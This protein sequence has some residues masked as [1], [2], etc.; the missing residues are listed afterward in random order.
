MEGDIGI[1]RTWKLVKQVWMTIKMKH[2]DG[3][4]RS[5]KSVHHLLLS[6][7]HHETVEADEHV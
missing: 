2:K 5:N 4:W 3:R 6:S 7:E 1:Y